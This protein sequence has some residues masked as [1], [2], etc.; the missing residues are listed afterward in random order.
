MTTR[1]RNLQ[2]L[3]K[4]KGTKTLIAG[5][6][7]TLKGDDGAGVLVCEKLKDKVTAEVICA[8]TV[9]ENYIQP[10]IRQKPQ[11][12]LLIDS[13]DFQAEPGSV[14]VFSPEQLQQLTTSTHTVSLS[15]LVEKIK[16]EIDVNTA[17]IGIQPSQFE[18]AQPP[19]KEVT[20]AI[21]L[22]YQTLKRLYQS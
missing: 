14:K 18:L 4:F 1:K 5:I 17:V 3:E 12:L 22:V 20:Q 11:T 2:K 13:L 9:P 8:G 7:N 15:F 19:C 6:G 21:E 16:E 10:I